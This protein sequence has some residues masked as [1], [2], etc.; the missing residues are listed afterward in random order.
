MMVPGQLKSFT[1][2]GGKYSLI[3][4]LRP[5]ISPS[6]VL[7]FVDVF[8]GSGAVLMN[9][10]KA[11]IET[12]NDLNTDVVNFFTVIRSNREKLIQSI[13]YTPYSNKEYH[14]AWYSADDDSV[15]RAR[16]FFI[17]TQQSIWAAGAHEQ[18][19]G[20]SITIDQCRNG[21]SE[22]VNK[23]HRAIDLL[24]SVCDRFSTVQIE[25][26]DFRFILKA[27]DREGTFFYCDPPYDFTHRSHTK[28]SIEFT[29]QDYFDLADW[30]K[31][32]KGRIAISGYDS[33]FTRHCFSHLNMIPGPVRKNTRSDKT[34]H[35]CLWTNYSLKK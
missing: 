15:E 35:E 26:R 2:L 29:N 13:R 8:G 5:L 10:P 12:Y 6:G 32:L 25:N 34:V 3:P 23:W 21:M 11:P 4:W 7:H 16:K 14:D 1:Y 22:K 30:S 31:K 28:Y 24:E 18:K 9:M 19:K 20:W 27:Y 33:E 17:R